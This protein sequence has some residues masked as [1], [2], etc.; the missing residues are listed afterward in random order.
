MT[1]GNVGVNSPY[2]VIAPVP[3]EVSRPFWSIMIP[4]YNCAHY[5]RA[6]L[7]SVLSQIP[8]EEPVQIEVIDDHSTQDDPACV[9]EECGR[10]RVTYFRHPVNVGPQAN[11]TTCIE[12]ARGEWVHILHGDDLRGARLLSDP[13]R[14]GAGS[15]TDRC[16]ILPDDQH[17][18]RRPVD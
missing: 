16:G 9:V 14:D 13:A 2:P 3:R 10:G 15:P 4:V 6:T 18:C 1:L 11:F 12:R 7:A 17:R 5:L 8:R